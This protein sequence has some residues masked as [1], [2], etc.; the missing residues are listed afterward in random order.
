MQSL[1]IKNCGLGLGLKVCALGPALLVLTVSKSSG[2]LVNQ[3]E[4]VTTSISVAFGALV[5]SYT[6][7]VG[8][9]GFMAGR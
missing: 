9:V 1:E 8:V 6:D 2:L 5:T 3:E 7:A 4:Q